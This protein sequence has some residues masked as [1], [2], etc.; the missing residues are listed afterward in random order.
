MNNKIK[1]LAEYLKIPEDKIKN[2]NKVHYNQDNYFINIESEKEY[3]VLSEK[4]RFDY[5]KKECE[6]TISSFNPTFLASQTGLP[7]MVFELLEGHDDAVLAIVERLCTNGLDGFTKAAINC[8]GYGRL[9][10]P[11]DGTEI[12]LGND[13]FAYRTY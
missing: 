9:L 8:D 10:S 12:E 1:Q 11:H 13:L 6:E 7:E 5:A 2:E 3:L 4:E